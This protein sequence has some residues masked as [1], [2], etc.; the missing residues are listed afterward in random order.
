MIDR[1]VS[2][3]LRHLAQ[4]FKVV[5]VIGPRQSGKTTLVKAVFPHLP[6]ISLENPDVRRFALEDTRGFLSTYIQGA[7]FDEAQ[8]VP[9]LFSYLQHIVD[10]SPT[11]GRFILTGSHNFLL[12]QSISQSLAGRVAYQELMPFDF[13]EIGMN[14]ASD[15]DAAMLKGGYPPLFD[16][17]VTVEDWFSNYIR[18][19]IE[20][21]VRQ[22]RGI[23]DLIKFDRFVRL[24]AG[25]IGQLLN[26]SALA[27]EAGIDSKTAEAWVA[28]LEA[29]FIVFRLQPHHRNFNKRLVKMSKLYFVDTGLASHLLG[30]RTLEEMRWSPFRGALFEN[31]IVTELRKM[32]IHQGVTGGLYFWRDHKGLEVD[33]LVDIGKN[34]HPIEIKSGATLNPEYFKSIV[35]WRTLAGT[36]DATLIYGG[37]QE[38]KRSDGITVCPWFNLAS[39]VGT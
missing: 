21:D 1:K 39:G 25:R 6:Y 30:I 13:S 38:Q 23:T 31:Q 3:R 4:S 10:E 37:K 18:T 32:R 9:E 5:A 16:Q 27:S 17:P 26:A 12:Q 20:R 33:L 19:Y 7:V 29:S 22:I 36:E 8:R 34:L 11:A 24:C 28:A 2:N 15:C 35:H 14:E